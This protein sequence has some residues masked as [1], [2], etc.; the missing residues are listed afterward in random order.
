MKKESF[1][2]SFDV[3]NCVCVIFVYFLKY[4]KLGV[5]LLKL[6]GEM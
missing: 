5:A 2:N 4:C 6:I 3:E 1:K